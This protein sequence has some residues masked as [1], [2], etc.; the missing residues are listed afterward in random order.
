VSLMIRVRRKP[1]F[2]VA[3]SQ[4]HRIQ[5]ACRQGVTSAAGRIGPTA[6]R[7]RAMAVDRVQLA[8][9]WG[10]PRLEHAADYVEGDLAPRVSG[11]LTGTAHRL[12]PPQ[13]ATNRNRNVTLAMLGTVA[14]VGVTGA[15]MSRRGG[16]QAPPPEEYVDPRQ[17]DTTGN[18]Q[19]RAS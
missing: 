16:T 2:E 7:S 5:D 15:M 12:R 14:V 17:E 10:A 1:H 11:F 13:P 3:T 4:L 18:G 19:V 9:E 6:Q 8:R